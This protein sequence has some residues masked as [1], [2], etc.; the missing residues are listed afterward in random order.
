MKFISLKANKSTL[1]FSEKG[2]LLGPDS[3]QLYSPENTYFYTY[4]SGEKKMYHLL[5][6]TGKEIYL[7]SNAL[8]FVENK[9]T[10]ALEAH[11]EVNK[12]SFEVSD[13]R[14]EKFSGSVQ[15]D[16][17]ELI[18]GLAKGGGM[19]NY[20]FI[21]KLP[22]RNEWLR[23]SASRPDV[24]YENQWTFGEEEIPEDELEIVPVIEPKYGIWENNREFWK[25]FYKQKENT[26]D[27]RWGC[28]KQ[29]LILMAVVLLYILYH[30]I[31]GD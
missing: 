27:T 29:F 7:Y 26:E 13:V 31:F 6:Q 20:E 30:L 12:A 8:F 2:F 4:T 11:P 19:D 9:L 24:S 5:I 25:R 18:W 28:Q 10:K 23:Q 17:G 14:I 1:K 3:R 21:F 16:K 22:Y 15:H